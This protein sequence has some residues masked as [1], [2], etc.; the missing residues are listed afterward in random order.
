MSKIALL[1]RFLKEYRKWTLK[2]KTA[3]QSIEEN[4]LQKDSSAVLEEKI[5]SIVISSVLVYIVVGIVGLF[6]VSVGGVWG[7]VVFAIGWLLSKAINKKVFGS[8]RAVESLKEDEKLL[9]EK[10]ERLNEKHEEIR[11]H[12]TEIPVFFTNYPSL[13][14]EFGEMIN[15]L[16]TYD[17]SN[18]ALKYR[19]RHAYLVKKYQNEVNTFHKIYANKKGN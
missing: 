2:L 17:A 10:L 5:A 6:G 18:L 12:L 14:R 13:K 11:K 9:L 8:Q 4:I 1:E 3:S 16:L 15:R 7:V 19:Y